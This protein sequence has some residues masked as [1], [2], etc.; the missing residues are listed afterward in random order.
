MAKSKIRLQQEAVI[1]KNQKSSY[2]FDEAMALHKQMPAR[3]FPETVEAVI[4]LGIN[5]KQSDQ[6]VR[7]AT[8]LPNGS[9]KSVK[10]AVFARG[11]AADAATAAG[12]EFV[13]ME[14][15]A[16]QFQAGSINVDV[17]IA[18]P[19]AMGVVGR[20]GP[21]LGPRGLMP[22]PKVGTVTPNVA[23][24]VK[25]AKA[26]QARFRA[27][28]NGIVHCGI[29]QLSFD[30]AALKQ[31]LEALLAD[32]RRAKPSTSKGVYL[33]KLTISTTM[34]LGLTVDLSSLTF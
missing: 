26:G 4:N 24:A 16:Q 12:A 5:P 9:G 29:G 11:A 34:G 7:G 30:A 21:V 14:E 15:L 6:V 17:V 32:L 22:N 28:K 27:D 13:G 25:N 8:L 23:E 19:D 33:K 31:N 3:K 20:L 1:Q 2:S 18:S 10:V